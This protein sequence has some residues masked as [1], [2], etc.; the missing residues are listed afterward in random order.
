MEKARD[1]QKSIYFCFIDD[2]K[3]FDCVDHN[4]FWQ[5]LKEMG[6]PD[7]LISLLRNIYAGQ[8][9][10]VRTGYRT[11]DRFKIEKGV[12][13]G[14]LLSPCLFNLDAE[15]IMRKTGLDESKV[16]IKIALRNINN[17]RYAD[18]TTLLAESKQELKSLLMRVKKES[19]KVGL[20]LNIKKTKIMVSSPLNSLKI[21]GEEMEVVTDFIFLRSKISADGDCSQEIK[22]H[23]LLGRKTMANLDSILKNRDITLPTKVHIVKAMV[24]P[25][26]MYGYE[27]WIVRKAECQ[28]IETFELWFWRRLL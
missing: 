16:A 6:V 7:H 21:D 13:Q 2:A 3:A 1:F 14:C 15:H 27:S 17:L 8:E 25:V 12:W 23:F 26:A 24:F 5:V 28:R 19:T 9:A 18:D 20:K 4:K 22:R 11:T 10:T